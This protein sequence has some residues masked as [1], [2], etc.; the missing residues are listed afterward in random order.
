[1]VFVHGGGDWP[2]GYW[3]DIINKKQ[4]DGLIFTPIGVRYSDIFQAPQAIVARA[5]PSAQKFQNDFVNL[6]ARERISKQVAARGLSLPGNLA[7]LLLPGAINLT[8]DP[9]KAILSIL[10]QLTFGFDLARLVN[11]ITSAQLPNGISIPSAALD[12]YLYLYNDPVAG[13]VRD[14]LVASLTQAQAYDEVILVSHSLGT[15]VAFDVLLQHAALMP[16]ISHWLTLGCPIHKVMLLRPRPLPM[17]LP[18][19]RIPNWFNIYDTADIIAGTLGPSI[20]LL[21]CFV[22]D[23]FVKVGDAMP[24]AHDYF[25]NDASLQLIAD[26]LR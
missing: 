20:D 8:I 10:S 26:T 5:M 9:Q 1:M 22:H 17:P 3:N 18:H 13:Q 6:I 7:A 4:F 25:N 24:Q 15:V 12:V 2:D 11:E 21:G 19:A 14:R 16:K 23:I